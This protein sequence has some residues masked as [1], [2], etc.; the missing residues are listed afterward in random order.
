MI[1][2]I[3]IH[4][5]DGTDSWVP[6]DA[7]HI[8]NDQFEIVDNKKYDDLDASELFEFFPG[9]IV[10]IEQHIFTDGTKGQVAKR[11]ISKGEWPDRK[12]NEF[13]FM[14]AI[15][16]LNI[17]KITAQHYHYE[18]GRVKQEYSAGQFYYT[19]I[20]ET[21]DRLENLIKNKN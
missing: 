4:L 17:D 21:I 3:Y 13:K 2:K 9:D 5:I 15:G 7:K 18:I 16:Q 6:I 14:A 8:Q 10:E 20:I 11:L 12:F 19:A 1:R